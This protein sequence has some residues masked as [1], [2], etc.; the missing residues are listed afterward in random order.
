MHGKEGRCW[1]ALVVSQSSGSS[2]V[3]LVSSVDRLILIKMGAVNEGNNYRDK[4][5]DSSCHS[6][7]KA[8][9]DLLVQK[10]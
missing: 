8:Y 7:Q 9:K 1:I 6:A 5:F 10:R 3:T 2:Q 4:S